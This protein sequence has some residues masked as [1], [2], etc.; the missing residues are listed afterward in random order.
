[1]SF[2]S[3]LVSILIITVMMLVHGKALFACTRVLKTKCNITLIKDKQNHFLSITALYNQTTET[4]YTKPL[5]PTLNVY[6]STGL[7]PS[8]I[9][10]WDI[11]TPGLCRGMLTSPQ[12][13]GAAPAPPRSP[14]IR[15]FNGFTCH[16]ERKNSQ[17]L[18]LCVSIPWSTAELCSRD[19]TKTLIQSDF[20][21][22]YLCIPCM[23]R[24][25]GV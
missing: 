4:F 18:G 2:I 24:V 12:R 7:P 15:G 17:R 25:M 19:K 21:A 14:S 20:Q 11:Q 3:N 8:S 1:M 22:V 16:P 23:H 5:C 13:P 10:C 9:I 6:C